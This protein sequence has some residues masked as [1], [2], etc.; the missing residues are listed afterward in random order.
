M[1]NSIVIASTKNLVFHGISKHIDTK[2]YYLGDCILNNK[3]EVKYV[4]NQDQ[5]ANIFINPLKHDVFA[6]MRDTLGVCKSFN[7]IRT[8]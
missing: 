1:D 8:P 3:V 6:K 2:F 4:K 7:I 5:V